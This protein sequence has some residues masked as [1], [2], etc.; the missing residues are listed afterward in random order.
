M[1]NVRPDKLDQGSTKSQN[2]TKIELT[3]YNHLN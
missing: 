1:L 2:T 3:T